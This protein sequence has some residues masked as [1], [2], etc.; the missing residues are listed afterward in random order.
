MTV[1][2]CKPC[3]VVLPITILVLDVVPLLVQINTIPYSWSI[4]FDLVSILFSIPNSKIKNCWH[5]H[6]RNKSI[7][8]IFYSSARSNLLTVIIQFIGASIILMGHRIP[9]LPITFDNIMLFRPGRRRVASTLEVLS[10][11]MLPR[12]RR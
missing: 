10:T 4:A 3:Q 12:G 8:L 7:I 11:H 9:H 2:Y 5:Y 1:D 6:D